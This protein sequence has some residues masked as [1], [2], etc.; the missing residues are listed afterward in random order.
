MSYISPGGGCSSWPVDAEEDFPSSDFVEV[1]DSATGS[2][3]P[4]CV[5]VPGARVGAAVSSLASAP[6]CVADAAPPALSFPLP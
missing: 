4:D 2:L 5:S 3:C 1:S 6:D